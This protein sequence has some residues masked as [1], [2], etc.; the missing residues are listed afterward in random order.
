MILPAQNG[1]FGIGLR[2]TFAHEILSKAPNESME[3]SMPTRKFQ[4]GEDQLDDLAEEQERMD[5]DSAEQAGDNEG[6]S[7]IPDASAESVEELAATDQAIEAEAVAGVEDAA[8]HPERAVH[9]HEEYGRP[10]GIPPRA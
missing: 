10:N 6:L 3:V 2:T 1:E 8:D 4:D 5:R 9:T 7:L